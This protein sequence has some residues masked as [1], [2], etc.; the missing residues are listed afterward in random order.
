MSKI[1]SPP[2]S[3][4][5]P[6]T[7]GYYNVP[8]V[9]DPVPLTVKGAIPNWLEGVLYRSGPGNYDLTT[10]SGKDIHIQHW[11]DGLAQV[12]RYEIQKGGQ[13]A[14]R[15]RNTSNGLAQ[16]YK[17]AEAITGVTFCQRDPCKTIFNKFFTTFKTLTLGVEPSTS[18]TDVNVAV[19][20]TPNFPGFAD[21]KLAAEKPLRNLIT[22]TDGNVLQELDPVTLEPIRLFTYGDIDDSLTS[23]NLAPAHPQIDPDTGEYFTILLTFGPTAVYKFVRIRPARAGTN[24]LP[25]LDIL[26]EISS[27]RATYMHSFSLTKRYVIM[28]QWQCDFAAWGVSVL[29][30][31][32]AWDSFQPFDPSKKA[33][34]YVVDRKL[35]KHV[36]T[37]ETDPYYAFHTIN[38]FD[39]GEDIVLDI[40]CYKDHTV[41]GDYYIENL[42]NPSGKVPQQAIFR[43]YRLKRAGRPTSNKPN[44]LSRAEIDFEVPEAN[45]ELPGIHPKRWQ[46]SYR[47]VYGVSRSGLHDTLLYDRI[48]KVD[49]D[50]IKRKDG[51]GL[52]YWEE[53]RCT[54]SE[55]VF[56]P[57]PNA[58]E[59]DD[60]VLLSVVLDGH[61]ATGFLLVLDARS[62][63]EI[64][65]AEMPEGK[66]APHNFHG[67]FVSN[68]S[69]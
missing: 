67:V 38:A 41:I 59:E 48:I 15:S 1:S 36:S 44:D 54:P 28:T 57:S 32:N 49:L 66:I 61:R 43:R 16:R 23:A 26:A 8:E 2:D 21:S 55:P 42:R 20:P 13:V 40:A 53:E 9:L 56:V 62:L 69:L 39:E 5:W 22:T 30:N 4:T 11:F 50:A 60:G 47:Y 63:K 19:I 6:Y 65:R 7:K 64:A 37:F 68:P 31:G 46:K 35:G 14:Y 18:A 27:P 51:S 17:K 45:F 34:F 58:T 12:H 3:T 25:D 29:W 33:I 10:D 52:S 24:R